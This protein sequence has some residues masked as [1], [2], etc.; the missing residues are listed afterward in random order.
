MPPRPSAAVSAAPID[1]T[2]T[3]AG[4]PTSSVSVVASSA[5][6]S[7][8]RSSPRNGAATTSGR[9]LPSHAPAHFASTVNSSGMSDRR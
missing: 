3:S 9:P 2:S 1:P 4:V 6:G 5:A 7:M 8:P